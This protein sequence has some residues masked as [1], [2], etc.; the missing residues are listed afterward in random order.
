MAAQRA[1]LALGSPMLL[2]LTL[3]PAQFRSVKGLAHI[4]GVNPLSHPSAVHIPVVSHFLAV[5][6]YGS[7]SM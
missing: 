3:P 6:A 4:S 5:L 1:G 7:A 2:S